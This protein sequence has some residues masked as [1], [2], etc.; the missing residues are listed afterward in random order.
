MKI[1]DAD[2]ENI[3]AWAVFLGVSMFFVVAPGFEW[4]LKNVFFSFFIAGLCF[5][6]ALM[7]LICLRR[8]KVH[9]F[10]AITMVIVGIMIPIVAIWQ[11]R[12]FHGR[13]PF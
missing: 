7:H 1:G 4:V 11:G 9:L 13:C 10:P 12:L 6:N 8:T 2:L 3:E 5:L